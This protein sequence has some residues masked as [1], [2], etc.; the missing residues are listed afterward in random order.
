MVTL[1]DIATSEQHRLRLRELL[2]TI[3]DDVWVLVIPRKSHRLAAVQVFFSGGGQ[4]DYLIHYQAAA[5]C[6]KGFWKARSLKHSFPT[7]K[8][9]LRDREHVKALSQMLESVDL[10]LLAAAMDEKP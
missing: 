1:M 2:R 4:R 10:S 9:D 6:R 5:Y 7:V 8:L 3:I